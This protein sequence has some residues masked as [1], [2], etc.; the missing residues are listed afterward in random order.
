[1]RWLNGITNAMDLRCEQTL[2]DNEGQESL[3]CCSS[4]G[5]T[6]LDMSEQQ[7]S[8]PNGSILRNSHRTQEQ[9]LKTRMK[10]RTSPKIHTLPFYHQHYVISHLFLPRSEAQ[11]MC[12]VLG[13]PASVENQKPLLIKKKEGERETGKKKKK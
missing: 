2:G 10:C 8:D 5:H 1:M 7:C 9:I 11:K 4:W 6:E 3:A 13:R 12:G